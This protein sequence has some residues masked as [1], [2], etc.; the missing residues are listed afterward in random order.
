MSLVAN[1]LQGAGLIK[2]RRGNIQITNPEPLKEVAC[3]C[4]E[5]V[6]RETARLL[7]ALPAN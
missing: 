5:V 3:E 2:Y 1:T 4:Y 7:P 6:R